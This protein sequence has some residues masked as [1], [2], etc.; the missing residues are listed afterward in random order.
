MEDK[1]IYLL[2]RLDNSANKKLAQ[3]YDALADMGF[4]GRQTR[5]IPYHITLG[6]FCITRESEAIERARS[7][8]SE[9]TAFGICLSNIGLF[10]LNVL[11]IAPAASAELFDLHSA[12]ADPISQ[13]TWVAHTTILID[14]P[15]T[16]RAAIPEVATRFAPFT[17][18]VEG[19]S[20]YE[21]FPK[22]FICDFLFR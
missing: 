20:V 2:A 10:G 12:I 7:A 15:E 21:F 22:R 8:C 3:I 17:A 5:D 4:T 13:N 16:I 1:M 9:R 11:F 14:D 6:S 18:R 19:I